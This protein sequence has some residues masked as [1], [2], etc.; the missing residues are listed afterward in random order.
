MPLGAAD[1]VDSAVGDCKID[2]V[3]GGARRLRT[4]S[5]VPKERLRDP[6]M[7][8]ILLE[9]PTALVGQSA[10]P[11]KPGD[12]SQFLERAEVSKSGGGAY[13][14]SGGDVL[15]A[16]PSKLALPGRDYSKRLDLAMSELLQRLHEG[17]EHAAIY[18][19]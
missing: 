2:L 11:S 15:E 14:K 8:L 13:P 10:L 5:K 17:R 9:G 12:Q 1:F 16:R 18:I 4:E 3:S 6:V 7:T 19:G